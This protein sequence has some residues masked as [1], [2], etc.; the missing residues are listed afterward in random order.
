MTEIYRL[1]LPNGGIVYAQ[2]HTIGNDQI[3]FHLAFDQGA[4]NKDSIIVPIKDVDSNGFNLQGVG[5]VKVEVVDEID[6]KVL[7]LK[8]D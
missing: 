8:F 6:P 2:R 7:G 1:T 4:G 3:S 5:E